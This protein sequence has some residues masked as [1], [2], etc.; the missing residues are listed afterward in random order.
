VAQYHL[1]RPFDKGTSQGAGWI[2][3]GFIKMPYIPDVITP[4]DVDD[5]GSP[6][7][8]LN[9][10]IAPGDYVKSDDLGRFTKWNTGDADWKRVGQVI[11]IQKFGVTYDTQL[12]E[13]MT[14]P[15]DRV[16]QDFKDKLNHLTEDEPFLATADWTAM[17]KTGIDSHPFHNMA[18]IEDNLDTYGAQGVVMI[19]L[20]L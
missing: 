1:F 18:G 4:G 5:G 15:L 14:W 9:G 19:A 3:R 13:Y 11:D 7:A 17:F 16:S 10:A 12:M 6:V 20:T 8:V 2:R